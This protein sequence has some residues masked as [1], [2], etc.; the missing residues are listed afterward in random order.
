MN[1]AG[2]VRLWDSISIGLAGGGNYTEASLNLGPY[3]TVS[4]LVRTHVR[5]SLFPVFFPLTRSAL[6]QPQT[7][8]ASTTQGQF[9]KIVHTAVGGKHHLTVQPFS[10]PA[11][12]SFARFTSL[13]L[14]TQTE[15]ILIPETGP[16]ASVAL[17]RD[18]PSGGQ[19]VWAL[20]GSHIQRWDMKPDGWEEALLDADVLEPICDALRERFGS[21]IP[22]LS[23]DLGLECNDVQMDRC[24]CVLW[25][26]MCK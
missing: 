5:S 7:F 2:K 18:S 19:D 9:F 3:E 21:A 1:H 17:G 25:V 26:K 4:H 16:I 13:L 11:Q 23:R 15:G 6:L 20:V 8:V 10:R 14:A 22:D 12:S 24:V